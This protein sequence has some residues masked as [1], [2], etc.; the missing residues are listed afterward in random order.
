[1]KRSSLSPP[2]C[3]RPSRT[4]AGHKL[5]LPGRRRDA[6]RLARQDRR[7]LQAECHQCESPKTEF[8]FPFVP[9]GWKPAVGPGNCES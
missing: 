9:H 8:V 6:V 4:A 3:I 7:S 1:M 5:S 2:R